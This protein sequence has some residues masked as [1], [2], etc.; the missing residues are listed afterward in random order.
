MILNT[1]SP[2][3]SFSIPIN[4]NLH[5][6]RRR[7]TR[8]LAHAA[9][10]QDQESSQRGGGRGV[11]GAWTQLS[12]SSIGEDRA[13]LLGFSMMASSVLMF[14]VVGITTVKPYV[15]SSWEKEVHCVLRQTHILEEWV[16]CRGVSTVPCLQATVSLNGSNREAFLHY[17]EDYVLINQECFYIP[18]CEMEKEV[19]EDVVQQV[20][21]QLDDFLGNISRCFSEGEEPNHVILHR[22]YTLSRSLSGM[23]W[24]CLMLGGGA[25]LVG[26]VRM[27]QCLARLSS[28]MCN[29]TLG[30]RLTSRYAQGRLYRVLQRSST[31]SS[32]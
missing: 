25:L 23:L 27:T 28:E 6:A 29:E 21:K 26:L 8:E 3:T 24:P 19:V 30:G 13:I 9:A 2:R 20:K 16:D 11:Q 17:N 5:G 7:Q 22:K 12:A 32:S 18:T 1:S 31:Q 15:N 14:F 4:I 10:V